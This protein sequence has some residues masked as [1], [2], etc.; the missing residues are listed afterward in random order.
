MAMKHLAV[1][2]LAVLACGWAHAHGTDAATDGG[3]PVPAGNEVAW[4]GDVPAPWRD[5]MLGASAADR[6][7]DP[8]E[9]C[10]AFPD[11]PGNRWPTGHA[12][13]HCRFHAIDTIGLAE[14]DAHLQRGDVAGLEARMRGHL[15]R[16]FST[17]D[18]GEDIHVAFG[19]FG[20]A[21][22]DTDRISAL[23]LQLAPGSANANLARGRYLRYA[24]WNARG[25]G[26]A[27]ET[28]RENLQR[29]SE[30]VEQAIPF[31]RK[32]IAVEPR[33]MPAYV[34]MLD[35]GMI[36]SRPD[37]AREAVAMAARHD[38]A[39]LD[40]ARQRMQSLQPRW[41]GSY[42]AM[43]SLA[44]E[45]S[46][47]LVQRPQ[48]A[49][50]IAAPYGDRGNRMRLQE[51]YTRETV[52]VLDIAVRTGSNEAHLRDAA[53]V[54][55]ELPAEAGG[56]DEL[57]ALALML[58]EQRFQPASAWTHG[59]IA[60]RLM[61]ADPEWSL[62]H[63]LRALAIEPDDAFAHHLAGG[64]YYATRRFEDAERHYLVAVE[65]EERREI[66]LGALAWMWLFDSGLQDGEAAGKATPY[67]DRL[68]AEY[69]ANIQG[70]LMRIERHILQDQGA[71]PRALLQ[72]FVERAD[73]SNPMMA[74]FASR[75]EESLE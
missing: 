37:L 3:S 44:A 10:L 61:G 27:S 22:P 53:A 74:A 21:T 14:I 6:L 40:M 66:V 63:S 31:F 13:A 55:L 16:H 51:A 35:L 36:D 19:R 42:E 1:A 18:F 65:A 41:G 48:L 24:A 49:I 5:Y 59:Q 4:S 25:G 71:V 73:R 58:Q 34:G 7:D 28:P 46:R 39:C 75:Y 70:L 69:P 67:L 54:A 2:W 57:K 12:E 50:H 47:H 64:A 30:L 15:A 11:L 29:M 45:L 9:R 23:W 8:L 17:T 60:W 32:A 43:L 52:A 20:D 68:L 56:R 26:W 38:P 62:R 33:L 72:E